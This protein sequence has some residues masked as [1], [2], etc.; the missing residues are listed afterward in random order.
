MLGDELSEC[1]QIHRAV[2]EGIVNTAPLALKKGGQTQMCGRLD[3]GGTQHRIQQVKQGVATAPKAAV[4]VR[5]EGTQCVSFGSF[6]KPPADVPVPCPIYLRKLHKPPAAFI[7]CPV[8]LP[9][10]LA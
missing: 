10:W 5:A 8:A 7:S 3:D 4:H 2:V 6:H 1:A 9:T